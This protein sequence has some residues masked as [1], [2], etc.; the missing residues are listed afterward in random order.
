M[1]K[2]HLASADERTAVA[3]LLTPGQAHSAPAFPDLL[4][5]VPEECPVELVV[6]DRA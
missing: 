4:A 2:I 6:G 5:A 3:A 1:T